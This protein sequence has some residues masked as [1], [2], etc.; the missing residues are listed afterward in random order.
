MKAL[1]YE[2]EC[3]VLEN[4]DDEGELRDPTR[5]QAVKLLAL[6][7]TGFVHQK[8]NPYERQNVY[9]ALHPPR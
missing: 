7:R 5:S 6:I 4:F 3:W 9:I 2:D 8:W 1:A